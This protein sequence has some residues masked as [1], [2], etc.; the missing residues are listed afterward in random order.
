MVTDI[1]QWIHC[2]SQPPFLKSDDRIIE[3]FRLGETL[4]LIYFQ[5]GHFPLH[6][7]DVSLIQPNFATASL[8]SV[9]CHTLI[10]NSKM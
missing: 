5:Q 1:I 7:A 6:Q 10:R 4:N 9:R 3:L 8:G 2:S